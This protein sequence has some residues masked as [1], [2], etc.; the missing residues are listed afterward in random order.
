MKKLYN[1]IIFLAV[2]LLLSGCQPLI[3]FSAGG[4]AGIMGYKYYEGG[5]IIVYQA[6]YTKV[7]DATLMALKE[8]K[9]EVESSKDNLTSGKITA[10]RADN[11]P[12]V[13]TLE[14]ESPETTKTIIRVGLGDKDGSIVIKEKIRKI[15]TQKY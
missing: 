2:P 11:T 5:L 7:W 14:F 8:M 6:P 3:L 4:A 12:V 15:L 1:I 9:F 13:I 10:K